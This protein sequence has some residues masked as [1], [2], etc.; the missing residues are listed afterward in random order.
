[1]LAPIVSL[2]SV[3]PGR[4]AGPRVPGPQNSGKPR[5]GIYVWVWASCADQQGG[6][7]AE[8]QQNQQGCG[9]REHGGSGKGE[10]VRMVFDS[11]EARVCGFAAV[12]P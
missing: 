8:E 11:M 4:H 5:S 1:M 3:S 10:S 2:M 7:K 9:V 12:S 6:R